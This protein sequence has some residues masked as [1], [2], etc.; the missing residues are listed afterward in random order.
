MT[1]AFERDL[2]CQI[3]NLVAQALLQSKP[4]L[5]RLKITFGVGED[6]QEGGHDDSGAIGG[7]FDGHGYSAA[8]APEEKSHRA[9]RAWES[10]LLA[11]GNG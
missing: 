8:S 5:G 2:L 6:L 11:G 3:R 10:P 9:S 1:L 7:G 4:Q